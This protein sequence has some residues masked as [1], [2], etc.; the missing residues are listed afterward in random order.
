[1]DGQDRENIIDEDP[2]QAKHQ[3]GELLLAEQSRQRSRG[4]QR[5]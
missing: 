2:G 3:T 5:Q 4:Q 1:M